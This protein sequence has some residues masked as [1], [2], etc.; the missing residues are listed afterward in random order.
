VQL[1][2]KLSDFMKSE[3]SIPCSQKPTTG[4]YTKLDESN[5]HTTLLF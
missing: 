1:D 3:G 5:P 4:P 2:K